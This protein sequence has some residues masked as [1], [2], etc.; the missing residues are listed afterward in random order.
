VDTYTLADLERVTGAKRRSLQLWA[1]AGVIRSSRDTDRA[2]TGTHR[3]FSRDEAIIGCIIYGF[4]QHQIAIGELLKISERVRDALAKTD[5]RKEIILSAIGGDE[6]YFLLF[7]SWKEDISPS[8]HKDELDFESV[9]R[10]LWKTQYAVSAIA[11]RGK[12]IALPEHIMKQDGFA[13]IICLANYLWKL[14]PF[15]EERLNPS[16]E[17]EPDEEE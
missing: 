6:R 10:P 17:E 8:S 1:D 4:A 7:Q 5:A 9:H 13:A 16:F 2:G 11:K 12:T 14:D 3:R 15:H